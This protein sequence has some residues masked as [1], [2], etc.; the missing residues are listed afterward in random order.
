MNEEYT[1]QD[2]TTIPESEDCTSVVVNHSGLVRQSPIAKF[3]NKILGYIT[4]KK[5]NFAKIGEKTIIEAI[6]YILTSLAVPW[7][8]AGGVAHMTPYHRR[9]IMEFNENGIATLDIS[10]IIDDFGFR[11]ASYTCF[12]E[13]YGLGQAMVVSAYVTPEMI[14]TVRARKISDLSVFTGKMTVQ[15][16]L[17]FYK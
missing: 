15:T 13:A 9:D 16:L 14:L 3:A 7:R 2:I 11:T 4:E 6:N 17:L 8:D 5:F 10:S 12:C 1:T